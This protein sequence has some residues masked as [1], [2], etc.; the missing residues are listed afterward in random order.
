MPFEARAGRGLERQA[1]AYSQAEACCF[2][3]QWAADSAIKRLRRSCGEG[4]RR[5]GRS[6]PCSTAGIARLDHAKV[7]FVGG[8]WERKNGDCRCSFVRTRTRDVP[9]GASRPRRN[10]PRV[11]H[12]RASSATVGSRWPTTRTDESSILCSNGN[13]LRD[14]SVCEPAAIAYVE[15]AAAGVPSI[16]SA[17]GGSG[18]LIGEGGCVV[19]PWTRGAFHAMLRLSD[20]KVARE[21][22][23]RALRHADKLHV[24]RSGR[25]RTCLASRSR[26]AAATS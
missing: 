26:E 1:R 15:A 21:A 13:V 10:H 22:G 20:G 3:T 24:A 11:E 17:V 6:K 19:D 12:R 4:S 2:S 7:S 16:G 18:E 9:R 5:R 14:A 23:A 25:P 8:D